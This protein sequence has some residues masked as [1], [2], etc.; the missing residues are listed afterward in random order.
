MSNINIKYY[1]YYL[2]LKDFTM[3]SYQTFCLPT[4]NSIVVRLRYLD[5]Q[6]TRG[7]IEIKKNLLGLFHWI[8]RK[9]L[10]QY[11]V[12]FFLPN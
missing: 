6:R 9:C 2:S 8:Y 1:Y 3:G 12:P 5:S 7:G 4:E 10:I 11:H